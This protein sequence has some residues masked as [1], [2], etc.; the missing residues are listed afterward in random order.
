MPVLE[1]K[2]ILLRALEP[3]DLDTLYKWE[4]DAAIWYLGNTLT[5]FSKF[6]LSQYIQSSNKDIYECLQLRLIIEKRESGKAVGA[7]DLFGFDPFNQRAGIGIIIGEKDDRKKGLASEALSTLTQYCFETLM[8]KQVYCNITENN[9]ES[10]KLFISQG[11]VIT[12]QKQDWIRT[13]DGWLTEYF[14]QKV[15]GAH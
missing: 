15:N 1:N 9:E 4:N 13:L 14:L 10:L 3:E 12:G 11:F 7:I 8:L 2:T 5:P 6:T